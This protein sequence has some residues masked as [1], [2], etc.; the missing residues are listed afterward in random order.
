MPTS[1]SWPMTRR[2]RTVCPG[3]PRAVPMPAARSATR[4]RAPGLAGV[5]RFGERR[6][7]LD[8]RRAS[9]APCGPSRS[10]PRRR[11][12]G[13]AAPSR[14]ASA[15]WAA[16]RRSSSSY[17]CALSASSSTPASRAPSSIGTQSW[18]RSEPGRPGLPQ[19]ARAF[20]RIAGDGLERAQAF[21]ERR[22]R[23]RR[24]SPAREHGEVL[25]VGARPQSAA[26]SSCPASGSARNR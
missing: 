11:S 9:P 5:L 24:P 4:R 6:E 21:V 25:A 12:G 17:G 22:F 20:E 14:G 2:P 8:R 19:H 16:C 26:S 3:R 18:R 1:I 10:R 15:T 13:G 23:R 7:R